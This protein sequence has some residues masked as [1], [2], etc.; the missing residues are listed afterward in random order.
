MYALWLS[1]ICLGFFML[2]FLAALSVIRIISHIA[3]RKGAFKKL[4]DNVY[5]CDLTKLFYK[6]DNFDQD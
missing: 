1:I 6:N 5:E 3:K 4:S 2:G